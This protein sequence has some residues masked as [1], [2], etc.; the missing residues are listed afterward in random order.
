MALVGAQILV[1]RDRHPFIQVLNVGPDASVIQEG[2]VLAHASAATV[3][4][5]MI[6]GIEVSQNA[7]H[8]HTDDDRWADA[9]CS[10]NRN[11]SGAQR[12]EACEALDADGCCSSGRPAEC[13][14]AGNRPP[15]IDAAALDG[16]DPPARQH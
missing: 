13:G 4:G 5:D 8:V 11:L 12:I 3:Q 14:A 16:A 9:L 7:I 2:T 15:P 10:E 1:S 6:G